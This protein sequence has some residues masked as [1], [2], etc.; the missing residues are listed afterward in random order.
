[1]LFLTVSAGALGDTLWTNAGTGSWSNAAN[2]DNGVPTG[3]V[4][5][6]IRIQNGG[7]AV[8]DSAAGTVDW[9]Y[10]RIGTSTG[11]GHLQVVSGGSITLASC[12]VRLGEDITGATLTITGGSL[13]NNDRIRIGSTGGSGDTA[14]GTLIISG[15]SL[16]LSTSAGDLVMGYG[17]G[18][19]SA[20]LEIHG[21]SPTIEVY[22]FIM[23]SGATNT[24]TFALGAAGV[25]PIEVTGSS[26]MTFNG[27]T[28]VVS[29]D[30]A[31]S[32]SEGSNI[33]LI[34]NQGSVSITDTFGGLA[35]GATV[36]ATYGGTTYSWAITYA[37]GTGN[38]IVLENLVIEETIGV[39]LRDATN[40]TDYATWAIGMGKTFDTAYI[41][42]TSDCVLVKNTGS[43]AMDVG[44]SVA[45]TNWTFGSSTGED[46]CVLMGLF[47]GDTAPGAGDFSTTYDVVS[48]AIAWATSSG[49]SGLFEGADSGV[50]IAGG[51]G[52]KL[53]MLL[54]TPSSASSAANASEIA[55]VTVS[56]REN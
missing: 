10:L 1:M 2:W 28:L 51:S 11:V 50:S 15:G 56:C 49:G 43:V 24:V 38:D 17:P 39:T 22:R 42:N 4:N 31:L 18:T 7:T 23:T 25:S 35:E 20:D 26:N 37:G 45:G 21:T 33:T 55:T 27:T 41:M 40:S 44:L 14:S 34:D 36:E 5:A 53:Y 52:K 47:N 6:S 29:C 8:I 54:K 32:L 19:S 13:A 16:V 9:D 3:S 46:Q 30:E 48:N 12:A